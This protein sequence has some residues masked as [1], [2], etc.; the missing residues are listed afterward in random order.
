MVD[1]DGF[2]NLKCSASFGLVKFVNVVG[3]FCK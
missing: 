2:L 1:I 3:K